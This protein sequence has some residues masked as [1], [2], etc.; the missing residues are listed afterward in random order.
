MIGV[1]VCPYPY[2]PSNVTRSNE[3]ASIIANITEPVNASGVANVYLSYKVDGGEWWN[4]T[5]AF[6]A[7][8]NFWVT[9]VPG[10]LGNATVDFFLTAYD[11]AGNCNSSSVRSYQVKVI[12][13]GDINGDDIVDI[14]DLVIVAI[15]Y[16]NTS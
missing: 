5:M 6:N 8:Q 14:F 4:T 11:N 15:N 9:T 1:P 3:P 10:Q 7:T 2:L 13:T 12:P 16:G